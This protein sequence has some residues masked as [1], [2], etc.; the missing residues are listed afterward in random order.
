M[1]KPSISANDESVR[2]VVYECTGKYTFNN[3]SGWGAPNVELNTATSSTL[4]IYIPYA[5]TPIIINEFPALPTDDDTIGIE[6]NAS[7]LGMTT[8]TSGVYKIGYRVKGTFNSVDYEYYTERKFIF[9]KQAECCVDI[10]ITNTINTPISE[11]LRND[12]KKMATELS[13]LL[14]DALWAKEH[15]NFDAAQTLLGYLN[16]QCTNCC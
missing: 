3:K 4:E 2:I 15:G 14:K 7:V 1:T 13:V 6:I 10:V 11:R 16:L 12:Y 9:T 5:T 8:I